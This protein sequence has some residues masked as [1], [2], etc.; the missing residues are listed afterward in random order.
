MSDNSLQILLV[1]DDPAMQ[2]LLR[3]WLECA[4][5]SV[6]TANDGREAQQYI[7]ENCPQLLITDWEMP[8]V[9]GL[10]L[11]RWLRQQDTPRYIYTIFLTCRSTSEDMITA[12]ETGA[13]DFLKKPVD[14]GELLARVRSATRVLELESRLSILART[15]PLTGL[16]TRRTFVEMVER[17]WTRANRHLFPLSCVMI[18]IDY[19]KRIN[20]TYG[21]RAGDQALRN[22]SK[23]LQQNCRTS[24]IIGRYGGEEFCVLL[25]ETTEDQAVRW[26]DRVRKSIAEAAGLVNNVDVNLTASFGVAQRLADTQ[27]PE[28][29]IDLADQSLLI[30]KRSGR[31]RVVGFQMSTTNSQV[32]ANPGGPAS[33]FKDKHAKDVMATIVAGLK[34]DDTVGRAAQYFL[35]FR[36]NSAPVVDDAGK[37]VGILS[38]RDVMSIMLWPNWWRTKIRDVM[39]CNAVCYEEDTPVLLIYEFLCRVSVRGVVIVRNGCPVGM[40]SRASLL[41]WFTNML[42]LNSSELSENHS[43]MNFPLEDEPTSPPEPREN[44]AMIARAIGL[45]AESMESRIRQEDFEMVPVVVG[46]VSRIEELINDLLSYSRYVGA[47]MNEFQTQPSVAESPAGVGLLPTGSMSES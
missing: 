4:G 5:Y 2:R 26:A 43:E 30:A 15:D 33:F 21:H 20:D 14:K 24:D 39:R 3:K 45:E 36:F 10:G 13:D 42:A 38:E 23:I 28:E 29:L 7:L 8:N 37:L 47:M 32:Q 44:V 18:D 6:S 22:I 9:D 1:D 34:E 31:D 12:L 17:E 41:R 46:G 11:C 19:F 25:P 27:N 35:R 16:V 40:I